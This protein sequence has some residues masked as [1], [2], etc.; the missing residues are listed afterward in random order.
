MFISVG[1]D[2]CENMTQSV[3]K[4]SD[5]RMHERKYIFVWVLLLFAFIPLIKVLHWE[6]SAI[7]LSALLMA[8][9]LF[10]IKADKR[11]SIGLVIIFV[12]FLLLS[13]FMQNAALLSGETFIGVFAILLM[14]KC[15]EC[16]QVK[17]LY[18][19]MYGGL[20]LM[21]ISSRYLLGLSAV[22]YLLGGVFLF[23]L[24]LNNLESGKPISLKSVMFVVKL[25]VVSIPISVVLFVTF[26]RIQGPLWDLGIVFGLP[27]SLAINQDEQGKGI[28]GTLKAGQVSQLKKNNSPVLVAEFKHAAPS[29]SRLYWRGPVFDHY[30]GLAWQLDD[31]WDNRNRLLKNAFKGN[32]RVEKV[33]TTKSEL[34][35]YAVRITP[36]NSR[37]L[38]ALDMSVG[39]SVESFI[40]EDFQLLGIR[41]ITSEFN[42]EQKAWLEYSGGR[43]LSLEKREKY[44]QLPSASN[45]RLIQWGRKLFSDYS[46]D[47]DRI[48]ALSV[49]FAQGRYI[50]TDKPT[51]GLSKNN[52]DEFFF[53]EKEGGID[54]LASTTALILRAANI[55]TR[56]VSGYR[57]GSVIALTNFIVVRQAN[58]HVWV[59]VW[60]DIKG[61]SRL[62]TKDFVTLKNVD[63]E[64]L[65]PS[66][67]ISKVTSDNSESSAIVK[68]KAE[69]RAVKADTNT[70]KKERTS[71]ERNIDWLDELGA[72][73]ETWIFNYNSDRQIELMK[74]TGLDNGSWLNLLALA[75]LALFVVFVIYGFI[76]SFNRKINDPISRLFELLNFSL[77]KQGLECGAHECP[78]SWLAR[79]EVE[80]PELYPA[81]EIII[82]QYIDIRYR[83]TSTNALEI[84]ELNRDVKR[85]LA[86]L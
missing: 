35:S 82:L 15:L 57:G 43:K 3:N 10:K 71:N 28:K 83:A 64:V 55:P 67:I 12:F 66:K 11:I 56:L 20:L 49:H 39:Q 86:M 22:S 29:K 61:W 81:L 69:S 37:Y 48:H 8:P 70:D 32:D 24:T 30:D 16:Q 45:A 79:L 19:V 6:K 73:V 4:I 62:E 14:L 78:T 72:D 40:S 33:L 84:K 52:L 53:D 13:F 74:K 21:V 27:I 77:S 31:D 25:F 18:L 1:D 46:V 9:L 75:V 59:E 80:A 65:K 23:V 47:E 42:Y 5:N 85:L 54:H 36:N 41:A 7:A 50:L 26:P 58:A 34:V 51:I 38:Y 17:E 68:S 63:K 76:V 2:A 44:L 60:N